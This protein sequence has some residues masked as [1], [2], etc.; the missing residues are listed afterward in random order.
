VEWIACRLGQRVE[1][2]QVPDVM[3][4]M[5]EIFDYGLVTMVMG[6]WLKGSRMVWVYT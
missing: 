4:C 6:E 5:K 3:A 1:G 2:K